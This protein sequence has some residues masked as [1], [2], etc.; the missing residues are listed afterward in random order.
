MHPRSW[1][2]ACSISKGCK[3]S[4]PGRLEAFQ[5]SL[6]ELLTTGL[7]SGDQLIS[8]IWCR[9]VPWAD[10]AQWKSQAFRLEGGR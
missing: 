9:I 10:L 8:R 4:H 3:L 5:P 7:L 2:H 1:L 6:P